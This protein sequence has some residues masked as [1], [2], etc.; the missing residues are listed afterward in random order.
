MD[1]DDIG[2]LRALQAK[3]YGRGGGLTDA[4]ARRLEEL[5]RRRGA[6][7]SSETEPATDPAA[8]APV[9]ASLATP[10]MHEQEPSTSTAPAM[11]TAPDESASDPSSA[12]RPPLRGALRTHL[13]AVIV[14]ALALL[15]LGVGAGWAVFGDIGDAPALTAGQQERRVEL[16]TTSKYDDGSV[17]LVAEDGEAV[18]WYAT[19]RDGEIACIVLDVDKASQEQCGQL[20][21]IGTMGL[22]V[23]LSV[24]AADPDDPA[25]EYGTTFSAMVGYTT[26]GEPL[27]WIQ[28]WSRDASMLAQFDGEERDRAEALL[29]D[30]FLPVPT[31]VGYFHD[32]PVWLAERPADG[33]QSGGIVRCMI[34]DAVSDVG[35]CQ[36]VD[37]DGGGGLRAVSIEPADD[38]TPVLW[39]LHIR[40]TNWGSPYLTIQQGEPSD[41]GVSY[42]ELGGEHGDPI[43]VEVPS[44]ES[45]G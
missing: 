27:A 13:K 20:D 2:E 26:A 6:T 28:R 25:D 45:G 4:E 10:V 12:V 7:A 15:L 11:Q 24:P 21:T 1:D 44:S 18:V 42:V 22:S 35:A 39:T 5:D 37:V 41:V 34:V 3:A 38:G 29:D 19:R 9:A 23:S 14:A 16:Q 8:S 33:T 36:S 40:F 31:I 30:G 17:R 43:L 32:Q